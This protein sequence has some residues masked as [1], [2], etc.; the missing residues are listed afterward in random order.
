MS[1]PSSDDNTNH[2][3]IYHEKQTRQLCALHA[4]NN[5]FQNGKFTKFDLDSIANS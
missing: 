3:P 1:S 5:L 4:L 2:I